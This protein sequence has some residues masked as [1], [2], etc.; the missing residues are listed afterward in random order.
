MAKFTNIGGK[1]DEVDKM[2]N[3][4]LDDYEDNHDD[5]KESIVGDDNDHGDLGPT[6][7]P[8]LMTGKSKLVTTKVLS[9]LGYFEPMAIAIIMPSLVGTINPQL[10]HDL[11]VMPKLHDITIAQPIA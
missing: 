9:K 8:H 3:M 7:K 2:W 5:D 11:N 4:A 6:F 10:A 1:L